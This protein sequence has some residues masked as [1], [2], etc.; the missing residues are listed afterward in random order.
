MTLRLSEAEFQQ[1]VTER[2]SSQQEGIRRRLQGKK[3][4]EVPISL[5]KSIT[6]TPDAVLLPAKATA[7]APKMNK[8]EA[9]YAQHLDLLLYS[10]QITWWKDHPFNLRLSGMKCYYAVDFM[11]I[12]H[13]M[14]VELHETKGFMRDDAFVKFKVASE[15]YPHFVF[16]LITKSKG[17]FVE[18]AAL[19]GQWLR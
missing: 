10:K 19:A 7:S 17:E 8:L 18:R 5:K 14:T 16:K 4:P 15:Q 3:P 6:A 2:A 12:A 13:D 11:V 1:L 9:S